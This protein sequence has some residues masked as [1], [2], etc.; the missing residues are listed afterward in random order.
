MLSILPFMHPDLYNGSGVQQ[1]CVI[2]HPIN[3]IILL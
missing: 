2:I 1:L 3:S